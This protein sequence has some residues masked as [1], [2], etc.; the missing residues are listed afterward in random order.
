MTEER[1]LPGGLEEAVDFLW[2]C[3]L[4]CGFRKSV[5]ICSGLEAPWSE[6]G[7]NPTRAPVN[8]GEHLERAAVQCQE[9]DLW[10]LL[11]A[12]RCLQLV[13]D[14]DSRD[15]DSWDTHFEEVE[16]LHRE[17]GSVERD[18]AWGATLAGRLTR[19]AGEPARAR[20]ILC[21]AATL[22]EKLGD[23]GS[24]AQAQELMDDVDG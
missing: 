18:T 7:W 1:G 14:A 16:R 5:R 9:K 11:G 20:Q 8:P 3:L 10:G 6:A 21:L 23:D 19:D 24:V 17:S 4:P 15:W 12:V 13:A 22:W 2:K